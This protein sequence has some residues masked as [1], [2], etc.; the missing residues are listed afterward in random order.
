MTEQLERFEEDTLWFEENFRRLQEVYGGKYI[1]I[2]NCRVIAVAD[3]LYDL[4]DDLKKKGKDLEFLVVEY[5]YPKG[6]V[7]II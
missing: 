2:E 3:T 4:I 1:A 5:I 7:V 6:S